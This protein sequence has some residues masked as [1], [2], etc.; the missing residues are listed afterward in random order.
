MGARRRCL[1]R[2]KRH[3]VWELQKAH[4]QRAMLYKANTK[5]KEVIEKRVNGT[6]IVSKTGTNHK[7]APMKLIIIQAGMSSAV[8]ITAP[9]L[10]DTVTPFT[11]SS[12]A[13]RFV[14]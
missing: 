5:K 8:L 14:A 13:D 12:S 9:V 1:Q 2:V 7:Q 10:L 11:T 3:E 6:F 4:I